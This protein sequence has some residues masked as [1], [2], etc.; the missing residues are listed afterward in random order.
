MHS[1][2]TSQIFSNVSHTTDSRVNL[3]YYLW[4]YVYMLGF[5]SRECE[6]SVLMG[7]NGQ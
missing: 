4:S 6:L 2:M 1:F 5:E 3:L 7:V